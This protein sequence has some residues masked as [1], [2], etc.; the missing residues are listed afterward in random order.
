MYAELSVEEIWQRAELRE[1][2]SELK[3][4]PLVVLVRE[5][6]FSSSAISICKL[7][8]LGTYDTINDYMHENGVLKNSSIEKCR[9]PQVVTVP[10]VECDTREEAASSDPPPSDV[11]QRSHPSQQHTVCLSV[12][13]EFLEVYKFFNNELVWFRP[14][15]PF[16]LDRAVLV[17]TRSTAKSSQEHLDGFAKQLYA[18]VR[19]SPYPII[20]HTSFDYYFLFVASEITNVDVSINMCMSH[21]M[22]FRVMET[23][24]LRQGSITEK[25]IV[26][27]L[28]PCSSPTNP[29]PVPRPEL[30][31]D[32]KRHRFS[33]T[34]EIDDSGEIDVLHPRHKF[35]SA[36]ELEQTSEDSEQDNALDISVV[37]MSDFK[38]LPHFIVVPKALAT[39]YSIYNYQ[40]VVVTAF[41]SISHS[42]D[43]ED[44]TDVVLPLSVSPSGKDKSGA[45]KHFA[46]AVLYE[47]M[48]ELER[49]VPRPCRDWDYGPGEGGAFVHPEMFFSLFPE[50]L[51]LSRNCTYRVNISVREILLR[52]CGECMIHVAL[53]THTNAHTLTP[54]HTHLNQCTH[55]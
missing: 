29:L 31:L 40:H 47:G 32:A 12:T 7:N 43:I 5:K 37:T 16:P 2:S 14:A 21:L 36:S 44:L 18:K 27:I 10:V 42:V 17:P 28:P 3:R 48:L 15:T 51:A 30:S 4:D 11:P 35:S 45:T 38:L 50:T 9:F 46:I 55:T 8:V 52:L 49:Y 23:L 1:K 41:E 33:K 24:P 53:H 13:R 39:I 34:H 54:M 19:S 20:V 25:T 6:R 22:T 26:T